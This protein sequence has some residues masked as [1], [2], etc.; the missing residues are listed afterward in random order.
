MIL[1][2]TKNLIHAKPIKNELQQIIANLLFNAK[3][4]LL[5]NAPKKELII[6]II[7]EDRNKEYCIQVE[8]NGPGIHTSMRSLL[9]KPFKST[10]GDKG[11][12]NGLYLSQLIATQ[13]LEGTLSLLSY[14]NPTTFLLSF[15]KYLGNF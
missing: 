9:F 11:T 8:D 2:Q 1:S 12:G 14:Q 13:K 4:A 15:Q 3:E 6:K 5:E 7:L 10:K